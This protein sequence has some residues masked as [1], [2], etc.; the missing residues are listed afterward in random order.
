MCL[1]YYAVDK[2][3]KR[4]FKQN[5]LPLVPTFFFLAIDQQLSM[6]SKILSFPQTFC[7]VTIVFCKRIADKYDEKRK[8]TALFSGTDCSANN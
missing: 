3:N 8:K 1:V 2:R 6:K 5:L 4:F 7:T